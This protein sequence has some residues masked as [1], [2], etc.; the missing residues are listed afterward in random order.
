MS[1]LPVLPLLSYRETWEAEFETAEAKF[2]KLKVR[3]NDASFASLP[4]YERLRLH[5][6]F[7]RVGASLGAIF[8]M[9]FA[10]TDAYRNWALDYLG[11]ALEWR[12]A[13]GFEMPSGLP[14]VEIRRRLNEARELRPSS[15]DET[16]V[17]EWQTKVTAILSKS[18]SQEVEALAWALH[19]VGGDRVR[20]A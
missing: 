5:T 6:E 20:H 16:A 19:R 12:P 8:E 14:I 18:Y 4:E 17:L 13:A 15:S 10:T 2:E 3:V 7:T 1:A 11:V 9:Q